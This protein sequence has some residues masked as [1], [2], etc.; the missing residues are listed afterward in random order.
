MGKENAADMCAIPSGGTASP[1]PLI[2]AA[3]EAY[4]HAYAPYSHYRVGAAVLADDGQVY[5]GVNVENAVYPLTICAERAAIFRAVAAGA[6]KITA[7][8]VLTENGGAPCGACRQVMR[9]FGD[10]SMP[11]I[12]A[13]RS[14]ASRTHTLGELLPNSFSVNDLD[15]QG[16]DTDVA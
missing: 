1:E 12:I 8:A 5:T 3:R 15:P 13:D 10:D 9:E 16:H 7:V 4:E 6:R 11:I 14:G 2:A